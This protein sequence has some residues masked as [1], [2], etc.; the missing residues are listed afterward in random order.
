M[1]VSLPFPHKS[2]FPN[3]KAGK[4]WRVSHEAKVAAR[5]GAIKA[6]YDAINA[7]ETLPEWGSGSIPLS[8]VFVAPDKRR[9]D[10]DGCLSAQKGA[11]DGIAK[12][13]GLDDSRFRPILLNY[14]AGTKPGACI[15]AVGVQI[16]SSQVIA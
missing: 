14:V 2:L 13:L 15:V 11:L 6:T 4:S 16:I 3:A 1:I 7:L 9:R 8:I 10:L 12:A 5:E